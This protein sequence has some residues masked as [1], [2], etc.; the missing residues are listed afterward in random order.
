MIPIKVAITGLPTMLAEVLK[1]FFASQTDI[2]V[3]ATHGISEPTELVHTCG[4]DIVVVG[5]GPGLPKD[6]GLLFESIPQIAV[7]AIS[8]SGREASRFRLVG[9]QVKLDDASPQDVVDT[10]RGTADRCLFPARGS[11]G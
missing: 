2:E 1:A 5:G 9:E 7:L 6:A 10:I 4:A 8:P 11:D 3:V